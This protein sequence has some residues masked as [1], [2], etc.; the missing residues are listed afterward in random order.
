MTGLTPNDY[1]L[2]LRVKKAQELLA[3]SRQSLTD[4]GLATGFSSGQYFSN[5][6][7]KY[8]GQTPREY[9]RGTR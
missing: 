6:F 8:T 9:Q 1:L 2:R 7:R 5:V 3:Q 4:V